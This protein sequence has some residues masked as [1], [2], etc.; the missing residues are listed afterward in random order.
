MRPLIG[1]TSSVDEEKGEAKLSLDYSDAILKAGGMPLLIPPGIEDI[2][3]VLSSV[4]GLVFTGGVDID[5]AFYDERPHP[6]MGR[7]SPSRDAME[8]PLA[9]EA[10][11]RGTPILGICRGAQVVAVAAGGTLFQDIPSQVGGAMKHYQ[12]APRWY[13]THKVILD[14]ET[15][16]LEVFGQRQIVVNSFHHQSVRTPG[17]GLKITGRAL[18]GVVEALESTTGSFCLC[19]QFHPECMWQKDK[20]F[21]RPFEALVKAAKKA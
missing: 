17:D 21:L 8:I 20:L 14:E 2:A 1:I 6:K 7:V 15:L 13:G 16:V 4:E 12:E 19:L 9:R 10:L 3:S 11:A 18:D 5:P